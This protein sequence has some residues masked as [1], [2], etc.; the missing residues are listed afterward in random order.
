MFDNVYTPGASR[1]RDGPLMLRGPVLAGQRECELSGES[2]PL[3]YLAARYITGDGGLPLQSAAKGPASDIP[4]PY[5]GPV[6]ECC[7]PSVLKYD[8][9]S[10]FLLSS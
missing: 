8:A 5:N 3:A 10:S 1:T 9:L 7:L 4:R 6:A 2:R